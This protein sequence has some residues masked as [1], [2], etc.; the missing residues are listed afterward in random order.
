MLVG[1]QR[2]NFGTYFHIT[3]ERRTCE[4]NQRYIERVARCHA[5]TRERSCDLV[6]QRADVCGITCQLG[7][8]TRVNLDAC[9]GIG[10]RRHEEYADETESSEHDLG[11]SRNDAVQG[12]ERWRAAVRAGPC[13]PERISI[14]RAGCERRGAGISGRTAGSRASRATSTR[15]A[16]LP[17]VRPD[18]PRA[19]RS[20][21]AGIIEMRSSSRALADRACRPRRPRMDPRRARGRMEAR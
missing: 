19:A 6:A 10:D 13:T 20:R 3:T 11:N 21:L 1:Q 15:R 8:A 16:A 4:S 14:I 9:T 18:L 17:G 7:R 5:R 2:A 12:A